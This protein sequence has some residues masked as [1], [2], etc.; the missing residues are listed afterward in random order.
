MVKK[1]E[2]ALINI[3]NLLN[4]D[5][6]QLENWPIKVLNQELKNR[7]V[8]K[9]LMLILKKRRRTLKN[10]K[11]CAEYRRKQGENIEILK[12]RYEKA[13]NK[14]IELMQ[15]K[16]CLEKKINILK[17]QLKEEWC[18]KKQERVFQHG[19]ELQSLSSKRG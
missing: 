1:K 8:S 19:Q 12:F 13:K 5:D 4:L 6:Y 3:M 10:R 9:N 15:R 17:D 16:T 2:R 7:R 18:N 14:R 11:Y